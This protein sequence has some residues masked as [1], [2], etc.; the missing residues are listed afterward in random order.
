MRLSSLNI[1]GPVFGYTTR[2]V[3]NIGNPELKPYES[4]D[5]D[6]GVDWFFGKEG[7]VSVGS[8]IKTL[9]GL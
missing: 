5:I 4:N 1:A 7:L 3:G 9:Y 8:S 2:T 6:L